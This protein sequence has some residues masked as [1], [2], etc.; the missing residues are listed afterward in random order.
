[1]GSTENKWPINGVLETPNKNIL[2][3]ISLLKW[4][5]KFRGKANPRH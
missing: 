2:K 5:G 3:P 4:E 1:M